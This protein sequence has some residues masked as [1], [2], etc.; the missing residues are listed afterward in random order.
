MSLTERTDQVAD[1]LSL[2]TSQ[3]SGS[4][5]I[6]A[7]LTSWITQVQELEA[8]LFQLY[9][10][11]GVEDAI[12]DQL[13]DLGTIVGLERDGMSDTDYRARLLVQIAINLASGTV[14]EVEAILDS[15]L[16]T[17]FEIRESDDVSGAFDIEV[18]DAITNGIEI[19]KV[20][21]KI[22]SAAVRLI[23]VWPDDVVLES[24]QAFSFGAA[25][26][27][28]GNSLGFDSDGGFITSNFSGLGIAFI[29]DILVP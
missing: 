28:N 9:E 22:K 2:L 27:I 15:L 10:E 8:A 19:F 12:G 1:A 25:A 3:F 18:E 16:L 26:D 24:E 23:F 20:L 6:Q 5:N 29:E 4:T 7:I 11:R 14:P 17:G 21:L 13:D